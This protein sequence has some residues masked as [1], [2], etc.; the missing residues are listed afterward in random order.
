MWQ[1]QQSRRHSDPLLED[2]RVQLLS[3]SNTHPRYFLSQHP[4]AVGGGGGGGG[5]GRG[6]GMGESI[7]LPGIAQ[8]PRELTKVHVMS[9]VEAQLRHSAA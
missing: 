6:G 7:K 4:A 5:V 8:T 1:P 3:L 2:S 9:I